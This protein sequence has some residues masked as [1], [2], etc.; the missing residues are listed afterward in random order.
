MKLYLLVVIL[1]ITS[2]TKLQDDKKIQLSCKGEKMVEVMDYVVGRPHNERYIIHKT[3]VFQIVGDESPQKDV[4]T[5]N[6][7]N[8]V[9]NKGNCKFDVESIQ[10]E[11]DSYGHV[12][13]SRLSG[14]V[15]TMKQIPFENP[16][17]KKVESSTFTYFNGSCEK[18]ENSKF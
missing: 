2:C 11:S 10:C 9:L 16:N 5:I 15:S 4:P 18:V 14:A 8:V 13:F 12:V 3:V 7:V 1:L 6:P 17:S